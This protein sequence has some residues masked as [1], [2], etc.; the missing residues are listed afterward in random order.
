MYWWFSFSV[1]F[2][3]LMNKT[4]KYF[5]LDKLSVYLWSTKFIIHTLHSIYLS[6][7]G[8]FYYKLTHVLHLSHMSSLQG[9]PL[10]VNFFHLSF[11]LF[12]FINHYCSNQSFKIKG[13]RM[14]YKVSIEITHLDSTF[15]FVYSEIIV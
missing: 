6:V 13:K 9:C 12:L 4:N 2:L 15:F 1:I 11:P 8:T 10:H 3:E 14:K 7:G 5:F